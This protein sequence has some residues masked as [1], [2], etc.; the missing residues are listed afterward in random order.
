[1]TFVPAHVAGGDGTLLLYALIALSGLASLTLAAIGILA[2]GRRRSLPYLLV[3]AALVL[4]VGRAI[5]GGLAI[6]GVIDVQFHNLL[7]HALDLLVASLL[8]VAVVL[9]RFDHECSLGSR[10]SRFSWW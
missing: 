6:T 2:L 7:E 8:I 9:A 3:A 1:M 4:L 5:A 10:L